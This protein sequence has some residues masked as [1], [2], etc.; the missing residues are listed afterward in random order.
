VSEFVTIEET[1]G[2]GGSLNSGVFLS[3]FFVDLPLQEN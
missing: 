2:Q 1:R 3:L